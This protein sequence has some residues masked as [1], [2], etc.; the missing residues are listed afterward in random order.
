M[1]VSRCPFPKGTIVMIAAT[2]KVVVVTP[3]GAVS[4]SE[5][6]SYFF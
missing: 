6:P 3:N 4:S 1:I 2:L 5:V